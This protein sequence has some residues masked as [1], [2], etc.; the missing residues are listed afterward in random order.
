MINKI[1]LS[2]GRYLASIAEKMGRNRFWLLD[3][4]NKIKQNEIINPIEILCTCCLAYIKV[5]FYHQLRYRKYTCMTCQRSGEKNSFYGKKH[6]EKNKQRHSQFM[7]GR[8]VGEKNAFYGRTHSEATRK[9]LSEKCGKFGPENP[10]YGKTHSKETRE[11]ISKG[12]KEYLKNPENL[13]R[14]K[15]QGLRGI[16]HKK[17]TSIEKITENKLYELGINFQYSIILDKKFQFDFLIEPKILLEVNGDYWHANPEKYQNK[18]LTECQKFKVKQDI[19]KQ[20]LAKELGYNYYCIWESQILK[21][22]FSVLNQII[23][24][25][26]LMLGL[27][28][29][30]SKKEKTFNIWDK[31]LDIFIGYI[32]PVSY[33][34]EVYDSKNIKINQHRIR[35]LY[36]AISLLENHYVNKI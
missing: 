32:K 3:D 14:L 17:K 30:V 20:L 27:K 23:D 28:K 33:Y 16:L 31:E 24:D 18:E 1:R 36:S 22:D 35:T 25:N 11:K 34:F 26:N 13:R 21:N 12:N 29:A 8:F 5:S 4:G 9:I 2:N 10:F 15:E 6:S 7:K 19:E